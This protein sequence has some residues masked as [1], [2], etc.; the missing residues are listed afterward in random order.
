MQRSHEYNIIPT[1]IP[2]A[3]GKSILKY[4]HGL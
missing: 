4:T 1:P 2:D 3:G